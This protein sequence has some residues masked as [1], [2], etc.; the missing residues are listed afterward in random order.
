MCRGHGRSTSALLSILVETAVLRALF[1]APVFRTRVGLQDV[2]VWRDSRIL[3]ADDCIGEDLGLIVRGSL[4]K[5]EAG[6]S[7]EWEDWE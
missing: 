1:R 7:T 3:D 5:E 2:V 6:V 4:I